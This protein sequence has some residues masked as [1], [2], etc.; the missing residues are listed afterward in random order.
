MRKKIKGEL[1][2]ISWK[3]TARPLGRFKGL[4]RLKGIPEEV[5]V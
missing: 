2:V 3:E 4:K 1:H 5:A